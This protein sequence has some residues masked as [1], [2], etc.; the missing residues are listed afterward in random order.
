M[1]NC[2]LADRIEC[3]AAA[4]GRPFGPGGVFTVPGPC[5][6]VPGRHRGICEA[7]ASH[8]E[9]FPQGWQSRL[10]LRGGRPWGWTPRC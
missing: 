5:S 6:A 4:R 8:L 2:N 3:T 9:G 7:A 1:R 10:G